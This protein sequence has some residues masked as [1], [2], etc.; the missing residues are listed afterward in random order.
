LAQVEFLLGTIFQLI[1][2]EKKHFFLKY[3]LKTHHL[4]KEAPLILS[5]LEKIIVL[6]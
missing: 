2:N 3:I 5:V 6:L 4:E 1:A